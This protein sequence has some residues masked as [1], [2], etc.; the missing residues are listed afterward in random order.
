[1]PYINTFDRLAMQ[2]GRQEGRQEEKERALHEKLASARQ[3]LLLGVLSKE[4]IAEV[5]NLPL[6]KVTQLTSE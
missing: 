1:M 6:E 5:L 3:L 4:Q 2:Q